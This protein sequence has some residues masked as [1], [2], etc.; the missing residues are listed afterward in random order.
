MPP[1][2]RRFHRSMYITLGLACACLGYA[3]LEFLPEI[4]G[5]AVVVL[6]LLGVA[7]RVEGRWSL[8]IR[9]DSCTS[10]TLRPAP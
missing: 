10:P 8:S 7:Y 9:A 5:L 3:E 2:A 4:S 1:I 6:V